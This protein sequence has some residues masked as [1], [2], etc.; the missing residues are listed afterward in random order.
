MTDAIGFEHYPIRILYYHSTLSKDGQSIHISSIIESLRSLGHSVHVLAPIVPSG[1]GIGSDSSF[2]SIL[3]RLLPSTLYEIAEIA[4][5]II[6]FPRIIA[7]SYIFKPNIIYARYNLFSFSVVVAARMRGIPILLEVN[8]PL[9]DERSLYGGMR[10]HSLAR[11]VEAWQ[12]RSATKILAVSHVLADRI[13]TF[14]IPRDALEVIPNGVDPESFAAHND[15]YTIRDSIGLNERVIVGFV[16]FMRDWHGLGELIEWLLSEAPAHAA[17]LFVGEGPARSGLEK[18]AHAMNIRHRV[19]IVGAVP[20]EDIYKYLGII[21]IAVLPM[22]VDYASPLKIFEY[23]AARKAIVAPKQPNIEEILTDG[24]DA[25]LFERDCL[26]SA[27]NRLV[28]DEELRNILGSR[29]QQT[30]IARRLTWKEN[31]KRIAHIGSLA[32]S[33]H[34]A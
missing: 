22:A 14:G 15:D 7:A 27:I 29:A 20:H 10:L 16:G 32:A 33:S 4:Y 3:Q 24:S 11:F 23:M 21:D 19:K 26:F 18:K 12:W 13:L 6:E 31:A 2:K 8:A 1:Q 25:I 17:L 34:G 28:N 9:A 5:S 30:I